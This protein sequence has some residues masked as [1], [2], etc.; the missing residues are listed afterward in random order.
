MLNNLVIPPVF[1]MMAGAILLPLLSKKYS[2]TIRS[3]T[4]ILFPLAALMIIIYYPNGT[5]LTA[6]VMNYT[7]VLFKIDPLSRI[8]GIIF[9]FI[10]VC[11]GIYAYHIKDTGQQVA[12]LLYAGG[13]IGVT[14]AGDIFT[15]Y[16]YLELIAVT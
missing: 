12:T 9:T 6:K 7:L 10:A 16:N 4:F 15:L 13:A 2:A 11:G 1:I 8:F 14:Y 3:S 5:T